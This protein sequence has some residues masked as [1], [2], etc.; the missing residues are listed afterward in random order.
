MRF[1]LSTFLSTGYSGKESFKGS[2]ALTVE[3]SFR[4]AT[5]DSGHSSYRGVKVVG[6]WKEVAQK[7]IELQ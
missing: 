2:N 5:G 1:S 4:L 7:G 6:K 3:V